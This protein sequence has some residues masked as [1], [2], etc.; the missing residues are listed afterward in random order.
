MSDWEELR[1]DSGEVYYYNYKTNE[2][3]WTLPE[4]TR[5]KEKLQKLKEESIAQ[6]SE[7]NTEQ[8]K[9]DDD[10]IEEDEKKEE[11]KESTSETKSNW[12]EYTTDDGKIYYYNEVTGETTW[13]KPTEDDESRL[14]TSVTIT[15]TTTTVSDVNLGELDKEF[16]NKP[17]MMETTSPESESNATELFTKMLADNN[18][19]STWSFQKVMEQFIDKPEYWAIGNP[20]ERKKCYEDYLVSKFQSELSNKSLL[21]E[22][23]KNNIHDEIK[24]LENQGRI[25]Y[26][27]RWIKV[28][29]L[30][31]DEDNP[32]FKHS[33]LSDSELAAIFYEY[34]DRLKQEH[35]QE[36]QEKKNKALSEL[37]IYLK[38]VNSTL[39]EKS[40]TWESLYENLINDHRF[41][42]NKNFQ[43]LNK[44]DILKLYEK[45]IFP[46]IIEDLKSQRETLEKSNYRNDRKARDNFKKLLLTLK[47]DASTQ[48]EDVFEEIENNDAFIELC[49]RNGSSPLE[50]F[51]DIV[52]EK[53][54]ILKVKQDLVESVVLEMKKQGSYSESLWESEEVFID[55]L[56]SSNDDRL[57]KIDLE[58]KDSDEIT[59][60]FKQL[61]KEFELAKQREK[62]EHE[63]E[64]TDHINNIAQLLYQKKPDFWDNIIRS[65]GN[66]YSV[67]RRINFEDEY[68]RVSEL[69][70]YKQLVEYEQKRPVTAITKLMIDTFVNEHNRLSSRKRRSSNSE[71]NSEKKSKPNAA[72]ILNY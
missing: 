34:T 40:N 68:K 44:L 46:R 47:I 67:S 64:V 55:A 10:K 22:K 4:D 20:I 36:I 69:P 45:E 48:F 43:N 18:V 13:E 52:D 33:M 62:L 37:S 38:T 24:K 54:Q 1:T 23:L 28:R 29:K 21:M 51:W 53:R 57:S 49:G 50:L 32:I 3:S 31:I 42:S 58:K 17:V 12:T 14:G 41:Q 39:V 27:T 70:E 71:S 6:T 15:M 35:D 59:I 7:S 61:K 63:K 56:K 19:D 9:E 5:K 11:P 65:E 26:N 66:R 72:S 16:F 8:S 25:N 2:T 30:W 60:I